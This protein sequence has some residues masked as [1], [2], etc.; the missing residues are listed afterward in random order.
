MAYDRILVR[1]LGSRNGV[2]INGRVVEEDR[3]ETGDELAIGPILFRLESEEAEPDRP[4]TIAK[5]APS[6]APP[7]PLAPL[8]AAGFHTTP[9]GSEDDSEIDLVP[10]ED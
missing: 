7:K 2:R 8:P 6:A 1:D 4:R 5:P 10:L 9:F 3:L